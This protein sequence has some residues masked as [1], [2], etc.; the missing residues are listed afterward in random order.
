MTCEITCFIGA[1]DKLVNCRKQRLERTFNYE[2][3]ERFKARLT[4]KTPESPETG[5]S[6]YIFADDSIDA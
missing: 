3:G 4:V 1:E 6:R 5:V 2:L